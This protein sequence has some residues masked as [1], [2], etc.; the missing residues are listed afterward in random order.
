M[1]H[2]SKQLISLK[3]GIGKMQENLVQINFNE[4]D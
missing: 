1:F 2:V 3:S 4:T